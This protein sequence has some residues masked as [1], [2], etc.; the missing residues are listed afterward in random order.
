MIIVANNPIDIATI[1]NDYPLNSVERHLLMTMSQ[2]AERYR[3]DN[4]NGLRFELLLRREIVNAARELNRSNFSFANFRQSRCNPMYW[5][6]TSNGGFDLKEGVKPSDAIRDIFI[7]GEKYATECATAMLIVYYKALLNALGED[8]F[9]RFFTDIYMMNWQIRDR[10]IKEVGYP[11]TVTDIL[12]GDR[13]YFKNPDVS[14]RTPEW[15]GENAIVLADDLYYGHGIGIQRGDR[16]IAILNRHR[17]RGS[18]RS[19][20]FMDRTAARP[21]FRRLAQLYYST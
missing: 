13:V 7:H 2:S 10:Y 4:M 15:Q 11:V 3:Y 14:P 17:K 19:A 8:K 12:L 1:I 21:D 18:T 5:R 20:Y 16:I 6:R 9:N